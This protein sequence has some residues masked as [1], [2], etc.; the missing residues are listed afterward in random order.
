M[1][2][3]F[4]IRS[5]DSEEGFL[6]AEEKYKQHL[7][8]YDKSNNSDLWDFF[9]ND[10]FHDGEMEDFR[11]SDDFHELSF[12][13]ACPNYQI[14]EKGKWKYVAPVWFKCSFSDVYYF[15]LAVERVNR[16]NDPLSLKE[17]NVIYLY[18]EINT[19]FDEIKKAE[20][21]YKEEFRSLIIQT[22]PSERYIS[23]VFTNLSVLPEEPLAYQLAKES[24][25]IQI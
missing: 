5:V 15:N 3:V 7:E 11:F 6:S 22:N 8:Q 4:K 19:L 23:M 17:R 25:R 24:Y 10:V 21:E 9:A 18:S 2:K 14:K 12:R 16:M 13:I 20:K 1:P